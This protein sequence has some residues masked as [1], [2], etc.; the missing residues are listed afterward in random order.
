MTAP[1]P[2]ERASRVVLFYEARR[3][4]AEDSERH[5]GLRPM[6]TR[7]DQNLNHLSV[8]AEGWSQSFIRL[9]L[10][11]REPNRIPTPQCTVVDFHC[12]FLVTPWCLERCLTEA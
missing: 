1:Y 2:Q 3:E 7:F 6:R 10:A 8:E 11:D 5:A 4:T 9:G 12:S